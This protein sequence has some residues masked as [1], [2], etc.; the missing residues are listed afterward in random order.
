MSLMIDYKACWI[1]KGFKQEYGVDYF[2][3]FTVI[4]KLMSYKIM[5]ALVA[6]YR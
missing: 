5:L 3:T 6:Y 4:A 1:A 2:K